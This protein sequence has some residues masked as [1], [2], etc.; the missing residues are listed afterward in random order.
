VGAIL[1]PPR[2]DIAAA[3]LLAKRTRAALVC[4]AI[5]TDGRAR[6]RIVISP[7]LENNEESV[8]RFPQKRIK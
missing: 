8:D 1:W 3:A 6:W 2:I 5:Y 7:A 4:V